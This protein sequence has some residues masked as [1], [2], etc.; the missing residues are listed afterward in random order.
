MK[1][2]KTILISLIIGLLIFPTIT[3]GGSFVSNL[4]AGKSPEEAVQILAEQLDLLIGRVETVETKQAVL[5]TGQTELQTQQEVQDQA[6]ANL[7]AVISQQQVEQDKQKACQRA[8]DLFK[9]AEV[10][11]GQAP[12]KVITA[13]IVNDFIIDTQ[14]M[15]SELEQKIPTLTVE[16]QTCLTINQLKEKKANCDVHYQAL[17]DKIPTDINI[18]QIKL[19]QLQAINSDFVVQYNLCNE[20]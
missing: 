7:Q 10:V 9:Q 1:N 14:T 13:T 20:E 15:I 19:S 17:L 4:I 6:V 8:N 11:Y 12:Y 18:L 16:R 5:E 3:F 2:Y